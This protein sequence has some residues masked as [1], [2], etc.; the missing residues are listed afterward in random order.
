MSHPPLPPKIPAYAKGS[1]ALFTIQRRFPKIL[2]DVKVQFDEHGRNDQR[3]AALEST[4]ASGA[5]IDLRLFS[6]DTPYWAQTLGE[7]AGRTWAEQSFFDLEFLFYKAINS[8]ANDLNPGF[9][10]FAR[11]RRTALMDA[12]PRVARVLETVD[13]I[14]L[15]E[16]LLLAVSG[17][18]ADLSQLTRGDARAT[19]NAMLMDERPAILEH[20]AQGRCG[21]V[22][23]VAD[24]AGSELC[25]D[26]VLVDTLLASRSEA[27][28]LQVKP[29]PMF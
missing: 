12:L 17:N 9:D 20:L 16:A 2:S 5:E 14:Q 18:E 27:V 25:F 26:L 13:A 1:F 21:S 11:A 15:A 29:R 3:W 8:I 24:N 22:Q 10:V 28:E 23:L 7:L 4:I 19:A 6:A